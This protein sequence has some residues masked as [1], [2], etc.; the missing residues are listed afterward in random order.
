M[1]DY[2]SFINGDTNKIFINLFISYFLVSILFTRLVIKPFF[3]KK[4]LPNENISQLLK[5]YYFRNF[6]ES[7]IIEFTFV[8]FYIMNT[9]NI[10]FYLNKLFNI[11]FELLILLFINCI[12]IYITNSLFNLFLSNY[13][14]KSEIILHFKNIKDQ[15]KNFFLYMNLI[16]INLILLTLIILVSKNNK[17]NSL[18]VII[19]SIILQIKFLR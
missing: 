9:Y 4:I 15:A 16:Y 19:I 6:T 10:Y 14:G 2:S 17:L 3:I 18:I 7:Y 11:K 13:N 1:F 8:I 5:T 12:M